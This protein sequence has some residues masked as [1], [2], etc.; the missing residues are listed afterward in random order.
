MV[1]RN[2]ITPLKRKIDSITSFPSPQKQK[3]LMGFLGA[4]NY[5][6]RSLPHL[7]KESP[8]V[9]LQPLYE[10][11]TR[12]ITKSSFLDTWKKENMEI[13]F[14]KAKELLAKAA[15]LV[16]QDPQAPLAL[17]TDVSNHGIGGVLEQFSNGKWQPLGFWSKHLKADKQKWSTFRR[18]L[19]ALQQAM[20]NFLPEFNS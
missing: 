18:E 2:G 14:H 3:H 16:H 11:A 6:R 1:N 5:Y 9:V 10:L 13:H 15:Q 17:T 20:R 4:I 8:A 12:K 19:Y 7:N